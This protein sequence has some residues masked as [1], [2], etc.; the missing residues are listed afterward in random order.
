MSVSLATWAAEHQLERQAPSADHQ[1]DLSLRAPDTQQGRLG[2]EDGVPGPPI[3]QP[4]LTE[5]R[6][7]LSPLGMQGPSGDSSTPLCFSTG[8]KH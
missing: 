1:A 6:P 5:V 3:P 7:L 2:M 8:L 4:P